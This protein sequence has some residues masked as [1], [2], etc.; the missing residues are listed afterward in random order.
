[1]EKRTLLQEMFNLQQNLTDLEKHYEIFFA[2]LE[3]LLNFFF[4]H[5]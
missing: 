5:K 1:M 4:S 2:I 3:N